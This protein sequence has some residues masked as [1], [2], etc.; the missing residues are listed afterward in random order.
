MKFEFPEG[1][2]G[3]HPATAAL[4]RLLGL[5]HVKNP[6][7]DQPFSEAFLL[8]MGGG[9]DAGYMLFKFHHLSK[10]ILK[11]GFRNSWNHTRIFFEKV[12]SR[13]NLDTQFLSF[14][15]AKEAEAALQTSL[16]QGQHVITW[17]DKAFLPYRKL[18]S[19]LKSFFNHQVTVYARDGR[20]WRLYIDDLS[21]EPFEIREKIFTQARANLSQ[22]NF[23][24]LTVKA[25]QPIS[26]RKM[27][28]NLIESIQDCAGQ[29][30]RPIKTT[31]ISSLETWAEK[32]KDRTDNQSWIKIFK[33]QKG[34][35]T[36]LRTVHESI[37]SD[38]T[39]GFA[40]RR[41]YADFLHQ[42]ATILNNPAY[43][44]AAGQYLQ[45][46][47]HWA[48][49]AEN[50]LPSH[51]TV[52]DEVKNLLNK[53]QL[54]YQKHQMTS[55]DKTHRALGKL[56]KDIAKAFPLDAYQTTQ[57]YQKLSRQV[58]LIAELELSA[59]LRLRDVS[60]R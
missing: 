33:A 26:K 9:L 57:L 46:S 44:A 40:L 53:K 30:T 10:P 16:K 17:V 3:I 23:L 58:K 54:A 19:R 51:I 24:M 55:Y 34:L 38:G 4:A 37:R 11:L 32:L 49:L 22:N 56:E 28:Q 45:L 5:Q 42:A 13:L 8:G 25:M 59:A 31:G 48:N 6:F 60:H 52:F 35:Y 50:A 41:M 20:L 36:A 21:C 1:P 47:N 15:D 27:R 43:N 12:S 39:E 2:A 14:T 7:T 29:L 18:P